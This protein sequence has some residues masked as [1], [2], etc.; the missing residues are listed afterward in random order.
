MDEN[1]QYGRYTW[2]IVT[3]PQKG[4]QTEWGVC[5][6]RMFSSLFVDGLRPGGEE[7]YLNGAA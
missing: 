3:N 4:K 1:I 7:A 5:R 2:P 6:S